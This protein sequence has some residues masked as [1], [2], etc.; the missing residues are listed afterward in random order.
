[1]VH[2]RLTQIPRPP[3]TKLS[4]VFVLDHRDPEWQPLVRSVQI[5]GRV[6]RA[7]LKESTR[8]AREAREIA[9]QLEALRSLGTADSLVIP[10]EYTSL[11][12]S[13]RLLGV[14]EIPIFAT[15]LS[16]EGNV[17]DS[18]DKKA[19]HWPRYFG[20]ADMLGDHSRSLYSRWHNRE[21][22]RSEIMR[23]GKTSE[24]VQDRTFGALRWISMEDISPFTRC[25]LSTFPA[26]ATIEPEYFFAAH[27][28]KA[29]N[30][31]VGFYL[32]EGSRP[33]NH[34][35]VSEQ[36]AKGPCMD[37][38]ATIIHEIFHYVRE[39]GKFIS[40]VDLP[41]WL[42]EG[43][44]EYFTLD[45]M[46]KQFPGLKAEHL[47]QFYVKNVMVVK[48]LR[49]LIGRNPLWNCYCNWTDLSP[50]LEQHLGEA[51][52]K[53]LTGKS[54]SKALKILSETRL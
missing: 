54:P 14:N 11:L 35:S 45:L 9:L 16:R 32:L 28:K 27:D 42:V 7:P 33:T 40:S 51:G 3:P 50:V 30:R 23:I 19:R 47:E 26:R 53:L 5:Y 21:L 31:T 6:T 29:K 13:L 34:I 20:T 41:N 8:V 39:A 46:K 18:S 4:R 36:C 44:T 43:L 52:S 22:T 17:I 15:Q 24:L 48:Q 37:L 2:L 38:M 1:M 49:E 25:I 12:A 10:R